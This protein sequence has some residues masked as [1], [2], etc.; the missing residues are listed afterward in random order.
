M[1]FEPKKVERVK[2]EGRLWVHA[3]DFDRVHGFNKEQTKLL[4]DLYTQRVQDG[5]RDELQERLCDILKW[6]VA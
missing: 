1:R 5:Y 3:A 2:F 6:A 4:R